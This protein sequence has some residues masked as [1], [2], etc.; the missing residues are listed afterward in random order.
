MIGLPRLFVSHRVSRRA[1]V[2]PSRTVCMCVGVGAGEWGGVLMRACLSV[3]ARASQC[4]CI[5]VCVCVHVCACLCQCVCG[6]VC[7]CVS[8]RVAYNIL[9]CRWTRVIAFFGGGKVRRTGQNG[10]CVETS[11]QMT[12][13]FFLRL[14]RPLAVF[15]YRQSNWGNCSKCDW[16]R[17]K[18]VQTN[19][20]LSV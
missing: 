6:P 8:E 5:S 1:I 17:H 18:K 4:V 15:C 7:L 10:L 2:E 16:S 19:A 14:P 11:Y 3:C 13:L 20:Y 12:S 9:V